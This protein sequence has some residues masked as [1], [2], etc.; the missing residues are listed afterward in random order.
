MVKYQFNNIKLKKE[1]KEYCIPEI[2]QMLTEIAKHIHDLRIHN[3]SERKMLLDV[4]DCWECYTL[5]FNIIEVLK[6]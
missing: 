4:P 1:Q 6:K 5:I 3:I 2:I